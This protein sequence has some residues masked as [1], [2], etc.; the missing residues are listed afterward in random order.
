M[1]FLSALR[2]VPADRIGAAQVDGA[3]AF[4]SLIH[5]KIPAILPT[6]VYVVATN[7]I[8]AVMTSGPIMIITQGGPNRATTTLI[9]MMYTSGYASSND[10]LASCVSLVAFALSF[11]FTFLTLFL[12]REKVR[13]I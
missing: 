2:G 8:L 10:S 1:L 3:G 9:Y 4:N 12:D 11:A 6:I 5:I 13:D 7:A